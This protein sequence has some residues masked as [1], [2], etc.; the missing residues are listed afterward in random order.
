MEGTCNEPGICH[1][2]WDLN[3][4]SGA[5]EIDVP[6]FYEPSQVHTITVRVA[7]EGQMRWGFEAVALDGTLQSVGSF[8][9][10]DS[11]FVQESSG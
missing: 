8:G 5:I 4:G 3:F 11:V 2:D 9:T 6:S 10:I 1:T 7:Q